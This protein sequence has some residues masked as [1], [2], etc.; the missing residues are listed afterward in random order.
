MKD[1]VKI[2]NSLDNL[3]QEA[4]LTDDKNQLKTVFDELKNDRDLQVLYYCINNLQNPPKLNE[5]EIKDFIEVNVKLAKEIDVAKFESLISKLSDVN[6]SEKD[7]SIDQV[8][9]ESADAFNFLEHSKAK[10]IICES[11]RE[12]NKTFDIDLNEFP[13]EDVEFVKNVINDPESVFQTLCKE[14]LDVLDEKLANETDLNTKLLI[15]ETREKILQSQIN[16]KFSPEN[17]I[18][19]LNL[20]EDLLK[21]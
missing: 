19:I 4:Y 7:K 14:C 21:S 8:L 16:F 17:V 20:K 13:V 11:I 9:F 5:S 3:I 10:S 18:E 2:K 15:Y 6:L 1:L 12:K